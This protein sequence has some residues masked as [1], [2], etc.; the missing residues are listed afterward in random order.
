M[1]KMAVRRKA[2]NQVS[3]MFYL[4]I[5]IQNTLEHFND[6]RV[7]MLI[8]KNSIREF[9]ARSRASGITHARTCRLVK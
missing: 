7:T 4:H 2:V 6:T 1:V 5:N 3:G 8:F 9:H